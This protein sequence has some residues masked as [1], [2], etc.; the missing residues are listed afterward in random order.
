M[1]I[2]VIVVCNCMEIFSTEPGKCP[3]SITESHQQT[4]VLNY[5]V[6]FIEMT[7]FL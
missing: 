1:L 6:N 7:V 4:S 2:H 5:N 3:T